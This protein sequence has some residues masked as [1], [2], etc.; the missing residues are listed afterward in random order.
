MEPGAMV[1]KEEQAVKSLNMDNAN[2]ENE[3]KDEKKYVASKGEPLA[4]PLEAGDCCVPRVIHRRFLVRQPIPQ[5]RWVMIQ[6]LG[7]P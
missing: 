1:S 4:L 3:K 5:Y 7:E 6:R 2:Q